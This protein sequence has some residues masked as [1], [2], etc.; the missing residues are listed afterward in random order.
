MDGTPVACSLNAD[1]L[2]RRVAEIETLGDDSLLFHRYG[3]TTH[4][5]VFDGDARTQQ[6]LEAILAA[7][8]ECCPFLELELK[9]ED[10]RLV[11]SIAAPAEAAAVAAA[12]A[13]QFVS[14]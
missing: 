14:R 4:L 7:E 1:D 3:S 11:L 13:S 10:D 9:R 8:R 2:K 6:C 12:L 5:L